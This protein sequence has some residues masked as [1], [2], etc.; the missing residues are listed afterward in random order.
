MAITAWFVPLFLALFYRWSIKGSALIY[1]PLVWIVHSSTARPIRVHLQDILKLAYYRI[2]RWFGASVLLLFLAKV[3]V[4]RA[5]DDF[6][7]TWRAIPGHRLLDAI[8]LPEAF[9]PWQIT[10]AINAIL[11]W[12]I[13]LGA[14]WAV[15]RWNRGSR[16]NEKIIGVMLRWLSL[17]RGVLSVYTIICGI[18]LAASLSGRFGLPPMG[19]QI[20]PWR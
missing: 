18:Y 17:V 2:Q 19:T 3:Y 4:Y 8:V 15:A 10:S 6:A 16:V 20:V 7:P 14:D 12:V 11:S 5:W 1:S 13:Y 9:P